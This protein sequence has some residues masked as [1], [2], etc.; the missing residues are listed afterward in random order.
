VLSEEGELIFRRVLLHSHV[1]EQ[2]FRRSGGPVSIN[3][4]VVVIFRAH[5]NN[6][7][8]GGSVMKGSVAIGFE[9]TSL[10]M[11]FASDVELQPPLPEDC[12]F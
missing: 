12:A 5:M 3:E 4:E 7:G 6:G 1:G 9:H 10:E 2:P 8:Y 11:D